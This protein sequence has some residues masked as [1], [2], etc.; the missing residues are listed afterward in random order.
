M[1]GGY[2]TPHNAEAAEAFFGPYQQN[3]HVKL[4]HTHKQVLDMERVNREMRELIK[5]GKLF[6]VVITR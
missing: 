1:T 3:S 5:S 6:P 2:T 4:Y